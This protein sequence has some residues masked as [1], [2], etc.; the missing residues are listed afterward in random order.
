MPERTN[1][2]NKKPSELSEADRRAKLAEANYKK[3]EAESAEKKKRAAKKVIKGAAIVAAT[4]ATGGAAGA[5]AA[6]S[7]A[8]GAA[9]GSAAAGTA[10]GA[11]SASA[12]AAGTAASSTNAAKAA[13]ALN[14]AKSSRDAYEKAQSAAR[15]LREAE[16]RTKN[17]RDA[18]DKVAPDKEIENEDEELDED[19]ESNVQGT[20]AEAP[21]KHSPIIAIIMFLIALPLVAIGSLSLLYSFHMEN[22]LISKTINFVSVG[23][24]KLKYAFNELLDKGDIPDSLEE[25][26]AV[27]KIDTGIIDKTT[28]AFIKTN[29]IIASGETNTLASTIEARDLDS[30]GRLIV[31]FVDDYGNETLYETYEEVQAALDSDSENFNSNFY[32][33]FR[34][35]VG[36]DSAFFYDRSG[37]ETFEDLGINRDP[38]ATFEVTGDN[39]T[40]QKSFENLFANAIDYDP[41]S[42]SSTVGTTSGSDSGLWLNCSLYPGDCLSAPENICEEHPEYCDAGPET[43]TDPSAATGGSSS[44]S[45]DSSNFNKAREKAK[46]YIEDIA[47][48]SKAKTVE[49]ATVKAA[50]LINAAISANESYQSARASAAILAGVEQAKSGNNG[51]INQLSTY[52]LTDKTSKE[53]TGTDPD[54]GEDVYT[55]YGK[56]SEAVNLMAT[57]ADGGYDAAE[58]AKVSRDRVI[59][60]TEDESTY[61]SVDSSKEIK[62]TTVSIFSGFKKLLNWIIS[63]FTGQKSGNSDYLIA[64]YTDDVANALFLKPSES[65]TGNLGERIVEGAS[66]INTSLA[67]NTGASNASD[68]HAVTAYNTYTKKLYEERVIADRAGRSPFDLSSPNT[69]L[70]SIVNNLYSVSMTKKSLL[71]QF[72]SVSA[73]ALKSFGNLTLGAYASDDSGT[74]LGASLDGASCSTVE[75]I[76][77]RGD[78][79]CNQIATYDTEN[80]D[81][82]AYSDKNILSMTLK[83]FE[84]SSALSSQLEKDSSGKTVKIK[85]AGDGIEDGLAEYIILGAGRESTTGVMDANVCKTKK[86][87]VSISSLIRF[88]FGSAEEVSESC[89]GDENLKK[90]ATGAKYAN[91][92]ESEDNPELIN[93]E[94]KTKYKYYQGYMLECEALE[95][96]GYYGFDTNK[97]PVVA[98]KDAYYEANPKDNSFEWGYRSSNRLAKRRCYCRN[99]SYRIPSL[100]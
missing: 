54:T 13:D 64:H 69:F 16:E 82:D 87:G 45:S 85:D 32:N 9:A 67:K 35:A 92:T 40:D 15:R 46:K 73:L 51:P 66:F 71:G 42:S 29:H 28:G 53:P 70:G 21:Q 62:E 83:D 26:L 2:N 89:E 34:E 3:V 68:S 19:Y 14:K 55:S 56:P 97:S 36:G 76:G 95:I 100:S 52:L 65:F 39:E 86:Q 5:A 99:R 24:D 60:T 37:E 12:G 49:E 57:V 88:I 81:D 96:L 90:I 7:A 91:V 4:V 58:A 98:Y 84:E 22:N 47:K 38:Y 94:W 74:F 20:S 33:A 30:D 75:A 27:H 43:G 80:F 72:S 93:S 18:V 1:E 25:K 31:R 41:N 6:G 61:E 23:F 78:I 50:A 77:G 10:A 8:G 17:F 11:S 44:A 48:N 59:V 63:L 79:Y